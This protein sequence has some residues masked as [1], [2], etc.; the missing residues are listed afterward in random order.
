M[1]KI[2]GSRINRIT[3]ECN[4]CNKDFLYYDNITI[5]ANM[6]LFISPCP[7]C[8]IVLEFVFSNFMFNNNFVHV[9][10]TYD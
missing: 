10:N 1:I 5:G 2:K 8:G 9:Y 3:V 4:R 6:Q 7:Y